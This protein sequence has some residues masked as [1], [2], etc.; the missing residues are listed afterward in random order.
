MRGLRLTG[1]FV[2]A[3]LA[4]AG[5]ATAFADKEQQRFGARLDLVPGFSL[6]YRCTDARDEL[7]ATSLAYRLRYANAR[8]AAT[9]ATDVDASGLRRGCDVTF[10]VP[11]G[12]VDVAGHEGVTLR[13]DGSPSAGVATVH[14]RPGGERSYALDVVL[15]VHYDV[16]HSL[17]IGKHV[18]RFDFFGAPEAGS[19]GTGTVEIAV[20]DGYSLADA[21][22]GGIPASDGPV[23]S[24][25]WTLRPDRDF[26]AIVTFRQDALRDAVELAP[27]IAFGAGA[28]FLALL[29]IPSR[30]R[31]EEVPEG[32]SEEV[33]TVPENAPPPP[34]RAPL[35]PPPVVHHAPKPPRRSRRRRY[36]W[37]ALLA[38]PVVGRLLRRRR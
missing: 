29:A 24:R 31:E 19:F 38:L 22:P 9:V 6:S 27:E 30:R 26:A 14:V 5:G 34:V 25:T 10:G 37:L 1:L 7:A 8:W 2:S 13:R 35:P 21:T 23:R 32:S 17:G 18:F 11:R 3:L 28:A 33:V 4:L 12:S 15:P 20:P 16:A 36:A